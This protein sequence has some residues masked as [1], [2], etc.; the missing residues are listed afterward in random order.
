MARSQALAAT[1]LLVLVVSLAAIGS[2][3]GVCGMSNDEFKLCQPAAAVN[4]PTNSPSAECCAALGK[5]NLSCICRYK[6]MAGIWLKMYHIDARRAMA[7]PG[8]CGL[9]MPSNCS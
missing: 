7:L 6:G 9:T 1:L 8:K 5:A 2:V 4:N 3:H